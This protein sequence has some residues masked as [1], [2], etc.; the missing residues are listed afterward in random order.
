MQSNKSPHSLAI[1]IG[2]R[3]EGAKK[4]PPPPMPGGSDDSQASAGDE[5]MCTCDQPQPCVHCGYCAQCGGCIEDSH[6]A[7]A[8]M[9][10]S[11][12][13]PDAGENSY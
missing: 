10:K 13:A 7:S 6:E 3:P 4:G 12:E 2:M 8:D 1:V 5:E 9:G 11:A